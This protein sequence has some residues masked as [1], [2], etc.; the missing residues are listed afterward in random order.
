MSNTDNDNNNNNNN[1][2]DNYNDELVQIA[3][4]VSQINLQLEQVKTSNLSS[5]DKVIE[6]NCL[7][8]LRQRCHN[9]KYNINQKLYKEIEK[10][11]GNLTS[12]QQ[13]NLESFRNKDR[14]YN[15]KNRSQCKV[16]Q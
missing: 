6:V 3:A 5:D 8:K 16:N 4:Q 10:S 14:K 11:G 12:K 13:Q 15:L 1:I 9:K 2:I 7:K